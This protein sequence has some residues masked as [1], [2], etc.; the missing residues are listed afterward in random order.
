M[1]EYDPWLYDHHGAYRRGQLDGYRSAGKWSQAVLGGLCVWSL[2]ALLSFVAELGRLD[3]VDRITAG[4]TV[5]IDQASQS[6]AFV[7]LAAGLD[8]V[9]YVFTGAAFLFWLHRV[10][11]NNAVLGA[12]GT[13]FSS[14]QAVGV[15]FIPFADMVLPLLVV[16]EA[17]RAAD[18]LRLHST[19][20]ER[21]RV[22]VPWYLTCWWLVFAAA[23][24]VTYASGLAAT[25]QTNP[26]QALRDTSMFQVSGIGLAWLAALLAMVTVIQLTRRQEAKAYGLELAFAA[27]EVRL[28]EPEV[29]LTGVATANL[30]RLVSGREA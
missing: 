4:D 7:Q 13:R 12:M 30:Q 19:F 5:S 17:W 15:W 8:I 10:V 24:F 22:R 9:A 28:R 2:A 27:P 29:A 20:E 1:Q 26:L 14:R 16:R 3:I 6:D 21:R 11:V 18:P 25:G 23:T